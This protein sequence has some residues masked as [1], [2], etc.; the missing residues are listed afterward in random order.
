MKKLATLATGAVV[1][2]TIV[3]VFAANP[4]DTLV[5]V[6]LTAASISVAGDFDFG[7][8]EPT[9]A[10][11]SSTV[12]YTVVTNNAAG[13]EVELSL[14]DLTKT[15]VRAALD[16]GSQTGDDR[17]DNEDISVAAGAVVDVAAQSAGAPAGRIALDYEPAAPD[18]AAGA[19]A[20]IADS[21]IRSLEAGDDFSIS[22][23]FSMP[24]IETGNYAGEATWTV[25]DL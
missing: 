24:W 18:F 13:Y 1:A 19:D 17:I 12:N 22:L 10:M 3:P 21:L 23:E 16:D 25:T 2:S 20:K 11:T 6:D 7:N 5:T 15:G 4:N 14:T 9:D 8:G